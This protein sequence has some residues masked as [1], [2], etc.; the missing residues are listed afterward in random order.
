MFHVQR[1]DMVINPPWN[2]PFLGAKGLTSPEQTATGKGISNP[3]MA[4]MVCQKPYGIQLTNV[5][6][7]ETVTNSCCK[8]WKLLFFNVAACFVAAGYLVSA[9]TCFCCYSI[10]LLREDL[11]RNLE[12]TESKPIVPA[13]SSSSIPADYVSAGHISFDLNESKDSSKTDKAAENGR[14]PK[15]LTLEIH[16]GGCFTPIPSRSYVGLDYGLHPLNVDADVLEMKK[17]VKDYKIILVYVEHGSCI[18]VTPK[19]GV[20]IAVDN[21]LRKGPIKIDS[22][23]DVNRNLTKE[24]NSSVE[25]PIIVECADDPFEDLDEILGDNANT[26]KQIIEDEI[27]RKQM[28]VHVGNSSTVDDVLDLEMLFETEGVGPVGKFKEVEVDVDNESEEESDIKG[29]YT[30]GSDSEDSDYD[31]K[32]DELFDDD[33]HIVEDVHVSM[34]TFS[35][36]TDPKHDLSIG[37]VDVH[38]DDL[39]VID[40][41]SFGSDLD[42]GIDSET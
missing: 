2:L 22:S 24:W 41:D 9:G 28:V 40:Y 8:D 21:H 29:D 42:D 13:G 31:P 1:V 11:S 5:S 16:H 35:F 34:N 18:F 4:V 39:D 23:P 10:L 36:T 27:T 12:L 20:A 37:V 33:E 6:S 7:T 17:Y 19:K 14:T 38:E 3:L 30:S 25:A 26:Q 15:S 32:H